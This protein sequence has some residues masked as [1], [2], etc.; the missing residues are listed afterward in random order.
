MHLPLLFSPLGWVV[1]GASGYLLYKAGKKS[2]Q[3][4]TEKKTEKA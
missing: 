3:K 2:G 4:E 1:L